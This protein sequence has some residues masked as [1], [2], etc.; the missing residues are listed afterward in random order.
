MRVIK[1]QRIISRQSRNG[2]PLRKFARDFLANENIIEFAME[3][4]A[5]GAIVCVEA[6]LYFRFEK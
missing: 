4:A 3:A 6:N 2:R 5:F 1:I